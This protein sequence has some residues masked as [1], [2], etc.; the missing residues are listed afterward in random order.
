MR[1]LFGLVLAALLL[2]PAFAAPDPRDDQGRR[3]VLLATALGRLYPEEVDAYWGPP[4]LDRRKVGPMPTLAGLRRDAARLKAD[5]A[6]DAP[7]PR[8]ARLAARLDQLS[9]LLTVLE[10]PRALSFDAQAARIYGITVPPPDGAALAKA[11][12]T[13]TR[14]LPGQGDIATRLAA[15]RARFMIPEYRRRAVFVRALEE[16][17]ARTL[18]HWPQRANETVDVIWTRDVPAAWHRYQGDGRSQLQINPDAVA[19]PGA[20]L[21]VACHEA[22]PGHHAQFLAMEAAAGPQGLAVEDKVVILRSG[23]QMLREGAAQAG[24]TLAFTPAQRLAF[25]RGTLFPLAG[26]DPRQAASFEK[27]RA[28][29]DMLAQATAPI[30]RDYYDGRMASGDALARLVMDAGISSPESLLDFTRQMGPY[31]LGYTAARS[32]VDGCLTRARPGADRWAMLRIMS[33][34]LRMPCR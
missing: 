31:A 30:L 24:V 14:L 18:A 5:V 12:A 4:A 7:S 21:D 34:Q 1:L 25:V 23:D 22:Y 3:F 13:L 15:W 26:L 20:A 28:A 33:A 19:D 10:K 2:R 32:Q 8:Q 16:C 11:R 27:I 6:R 9:A 17:R 29:A